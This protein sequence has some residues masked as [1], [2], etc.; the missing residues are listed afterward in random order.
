MNILISPPTKDLSTLDIMF[1]L[2]PAEEQTRMLREL[3]GFLPDMPMSATG[4]GNRYH[5][6]L[7]FKYISKERE[8]AYLVSAEA[9]LESIYDYAQHTAP[10]ANG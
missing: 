7:Y 3:D 5:Y 10:S 1:K 4:R 8:P 9:G 6:M 2:L